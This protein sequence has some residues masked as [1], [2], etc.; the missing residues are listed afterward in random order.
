MVG[1]GARVLIERAM[2][3]KSSDTEL[4]DAVFRDYNAAYDADPYYLT[5]PYEG[6]VEML[7][8][9]REQGAVL[10]VLSNKPDTAVRLAVEHFFPGV[11]TLVSGAK[12]GV[13][14]KPA[15]TALF[16]MLEVLGISPCETAYIGDSEPDVLIAKNANVG[17]PIAVS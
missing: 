15:P 16:N 13:P 17:L 5:E 7:S 6:V 2:G 12:D 1:N 9:L 4:Y 10:S 14:L 8:K 3:E 11:F